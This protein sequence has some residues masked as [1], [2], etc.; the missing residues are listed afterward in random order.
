VK[1]DVFLYQEVMMDEMKPI[2]KPGI[3][4]KNLGDETLL[5]SAEGE[6]IHVLN[7]T[8]QFIWELCDG[9]HTVTD[10]E[11]LLQIN[12]SVPAE[13]DVM[14]DVHRTLETFGEKGLLQG[15]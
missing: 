5:Y 4:V 7:T 14:A 1:A 15:P 12:F 3:T 8:A 11:K 2:R 6:A 13:Q 10:I 9:A